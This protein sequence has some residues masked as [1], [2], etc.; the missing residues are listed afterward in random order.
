M[1]K[2]LSIILTFDFTYPLTPFSLFDIGQYKNYFDEAK[3]NEEFLSNYHHFVRQ[4][5]NDLCVLA[6]KG[7]RMAAYFSAPFVEMLQQ[8]DPAMISKLAEL[9]QNRKLDLLGG[10]CHHSLASIYSKGHFNRELASH[11]ALIEQT[12]QTV[13]QYCYN[14]ENI[15]C[16]DIAEIITRQGFKGT[17]AGTISWYLW[18]DKNSRVFYNFPK[19]NLNLYLMDQDH[20]QSL[21]SDEHRHSHFIEFGLQELYELGGLDSIIRKAKAKADILPLSSHETDPRST[22]TYNIKSPVMGSTHGLS[23]ESFHGNALQTR[24]AREYYVLEEKVISS[25]DKKLLSDWSRL[26]H[27][28]YLLQMS[29]DEHRHVLPYDQYNYYMNI[30]NDLS[31]KLS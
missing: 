28:H 8:Y 15:Y 5:L 13:P 20:G 6:D 12:F 3:A 27:M 7:M 23:M 2:K 22:T 25:G 30:L 14:T 29:K 11:K 17:F 16:N 31:L 26:G 1:S 24:C 18:E 19:R 9:A 21:F 10:P 4:E